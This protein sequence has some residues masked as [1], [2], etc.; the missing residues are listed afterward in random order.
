M[1]SAQAAGRDAA[2][3]DFR[4]ANDS[5]T[6][7]TLPLT[8]DAAWFLQTEPPVATIDEEPSETRAFGDSASAR[9]FAEQS[10]D[11]TPLGWLLVEGGQVVEFYSPPL[12]SA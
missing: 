7:R 6:R 2:F 3:E 10:G 9:A 11:P 4:I 12:T 5:A 1:E 8:P